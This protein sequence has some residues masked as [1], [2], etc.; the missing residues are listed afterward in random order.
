MLYNFSNYQLI[1]YYSS[2]LILGRIRINSICLPLN[3]D[4]EETW[5]EY[6]ST[7]AGWGYTDTMDLAKIFGKYSISKCSCLFCPKK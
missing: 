7:A 1:E 6:D 2:N 3:S 4:V 5:E